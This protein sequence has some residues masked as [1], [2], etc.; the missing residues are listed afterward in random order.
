MKGNFYEKRQ[1]FLKDSKKKRFQKKIGARRHSLVKNYKVAKVYKERMEDQIEFYCPD[2]EFNNWIDYS[3]NRSDQDR[4]DDSSND[5][6]YAQIYE[7][8][9]NQDFDADFYQEYSRSNFRND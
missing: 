9:I 8:T 7:D 1:K 5:D 4:F 6:M 3:I 2:F